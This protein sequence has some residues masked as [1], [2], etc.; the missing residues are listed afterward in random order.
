VRGVYACKGVI[1]YEFHNDSG[2]RLL[3]GLDQSQGRNRT[4]M[5]SSVHAKVFRH[6][7]PSDYCGARAVTAAP[8]ELL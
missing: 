8:R 6:C 7:L 5:T 4:A 1:G 2:F 3:Q